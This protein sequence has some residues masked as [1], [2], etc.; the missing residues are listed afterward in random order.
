[1]PVTS[2]LP[3]RSGGRPSHGRGMAGRLVAARHNLAGLR[4]GQ[5]RR[6]AAASA[7]AVTALLSA[8]GCTTDTN[9]A[10]PATA[11]QPGT[12]GSNYA[13]VQLIDGGRVSVRAVSSNTTCPTITVNGKAST[14][15]VR[16]AAGGA[17]FPVVVCE[18]VLTSPAASINVGGFT[19]PVPLAKGAKLDSV[20]IVGDSGCRLE[21]PKPMQDCNSTATWPAP[22]VSGE[23]AQLAPELII[24]TGDYY[25]RMVQCPQADL[26]K[27]GGSPY[28]PTWAT[29]EADFFR[30]YRS[31]LGTAP[32]I[33]M[34]GNHETC[35]MAG[36]AFLRLFAAGAY[37]PG[38]CDNFLPPY[39]VDAGD[40]RFVVFDDS[41]AKDDKVDANQVSTYTPQMKSALSLAASGPSP[42]SFLLLHRPIWLEQ[43]AGKGTQTINLTMQA[44][45]TAVG[46]TLPGVEMVVSGHIH[47]LGYFSFAHRPTQVISGGGGAAK[48]SKDADYAGTTIAGATVVQGQLASDFGY[49]VLNR[50]AT[51]WAVDF[52]TVGGG[53]ALRCTQANRFMKC[54]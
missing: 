54:S 42:T 10:T 21:P 5:W 9:S 23:I 37:T 11:A 20:A 33:F 8:A 12:G 41:D 53:M 30:P 32:W 51:G 17:A 43:P 7:V 13:W 22:P 46:D 38:S 31:S 39:A 34:R 40:Q 18:Q 47:G 52:E 19:L 50:K 45:A 15:P 4:G 28:G 2:L 16:A 49:T 24:H 14:M 36:D 44:V 26:A 3:R 48:M 35:Q 1:M 6:T 25:Y 29:M 27:C